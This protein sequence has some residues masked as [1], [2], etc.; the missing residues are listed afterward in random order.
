MKTYLKTIFIFFLISIP[1]IAKSQNLE[2]F[3]KYIVN[4]WNLEYYETGGEKFPPNPGHED[5][6]IIFTKD[7][8]SESID[9]GDSHFGTWEFDKEN[10]ILL[11]I[12][13]NDEFKIKFKVI[14]CT[15]TNCVL[16]MKKLEGQKLLLFLVA[17]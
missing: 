10:G 9:M 3:E 6:K 1:D 2:N 8:K 7:H 17:K 16:E 11:V 5:D 12:Q 4:E 13:E 14:S 15:E